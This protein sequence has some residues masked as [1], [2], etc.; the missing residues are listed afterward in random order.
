LSSKLCSAVTKQPQGPYTTT[1][2]I[3]HIKFQANTASVCT[4]YTKAVTI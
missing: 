2:T 4:E 3:S 1:K